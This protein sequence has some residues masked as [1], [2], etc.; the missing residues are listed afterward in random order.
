[1]KSPRGFIALMSAV[2]ISAVLLIVATAGSLSGFLERSNILDSE[3]KDRSSAAADACADQA[4]LQITNNAAYVGQMMFPLNS[5][6]SCRVVVSGGS[7]KS[8]RIQA[9]SSN[10]VTN[11][12]ISYSPT[13]FAVVSWQEIPV[14]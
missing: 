1:M 10:A 8:I 3:L 4:F 14:Y 9:T 13:T 11:L 12:Q 2:I 5:I 7:P 6:D